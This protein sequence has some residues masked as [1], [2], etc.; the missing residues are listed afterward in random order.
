MCRWLRVVVSAG[1]PKP[2][3]LLV[4]EV[5]VG[6]QNAVVKLRLRDLVLVLCLMK[7]K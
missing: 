2:V 1:V 7:M 3:H 4:Q 5:L 6:W